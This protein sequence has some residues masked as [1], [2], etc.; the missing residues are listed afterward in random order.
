LKLI[1]LVT[2]LRLLSHHLFHLIL[3]LLL[4]WS[5]ISLKFLHKFGCFNSQPF[6]EILLIFLDL[7]LQKD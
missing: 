7:S 3:H 5:E 1:V 6:F 4:L 2:L